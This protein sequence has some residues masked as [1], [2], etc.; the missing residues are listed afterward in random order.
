MNM[1]QHFYSLVASI[2]LFVQLSHL[3]HVSAQ[4]YSW[5]VFIDM[6]AKQYDSQ[7]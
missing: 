6:G 2:C 7:S 4:T 1:Y 5:L 3:T